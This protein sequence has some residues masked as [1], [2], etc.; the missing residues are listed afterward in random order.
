MNHPTVDHIQQHGYPT[1]EVKVTEC[2]NCRTELNQ[3]D[4]VL[5]HEQDY[6]CD[7]HCLQEWLVDHV[8]YETV[9]I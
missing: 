6:F 7:K 4:E 8:D 1:K 9:N 3:G 5:E 2:E